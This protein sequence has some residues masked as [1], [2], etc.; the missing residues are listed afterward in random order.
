MDYWGYVLVLIAFTSYQLF[1]VML[2]HKY[3][4]CKLK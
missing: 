2:R 3:K 1:K 4:I